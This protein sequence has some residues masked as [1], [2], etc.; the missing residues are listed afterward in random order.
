MNA[1]TLV[2]YQAFRPAIAA[3]AVEHQTFGGPDYSYARMSWIKTS[4]LWM[5]YR[6]GW[7]QKEGQERILA[8]TLK[9]EDFETILGKMAHASFNPTFDA[10]HETWQKT[11]TLKPGRLQWD[12]DHDPKG[13]PLDRRAIQLGLKGDIL[14][15][16]GK[17]YC[18]RIEDVTPFV[19]EQRTFVNNNQLHKLLVPREDVYRPVS[20]TSCAAI[21]LT[22]N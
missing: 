22:M 8:I 7:A 15:R 4:F 14:E 18:T 2:V 6:S 9:L 21:G 12:P 10:N 17:H 11:L 1:G 19:A 5:M 3:W 16:F 13:T 20:E